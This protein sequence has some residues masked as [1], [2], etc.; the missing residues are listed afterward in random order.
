MFLLY[1]RKEFEMLLKSLEI[2]GF[3]TFPDKTVLRFENGYVAVVG[4]NGSGKSNVSDAIRW[5]M[6]EQSIKALR[7]KKMEEVIF[8]GTSTRKP[9][10]YAEVT[11]N[12][13]NTSRTLKYDDDSIKVTRRYYRSGESEYLINNAMVRLKDINELFMDTGL[14]R[15]GYSVIAQGSIE[16]IISAKGEDRRAIFEEASGI[17]KYRYR[18]IEA[19]R[20]LEKTNENLVRLEDILRELQ[21]RVEPLRIQSEKAQKFLE[22]DKEKKDLEIGLWLNTL[23]HSAEILR[24]NENNLSVSQ[25][26]YNE[27]SSDLEKAT[28]DIENNISAMNKK[29]MDIEG[30]HK[31][32]ADID[33]FVLNTKGQVSVL[34]NDIVHLKAN[35]D[36]IQKEIDESAKSQKTIDD[37]ISDNSRLANDKKDKTDEENRQYVKLSLELE[38]LRKDYDAFS[39][40]IDNKSSAIE[41]YIDD[42]SEKKIYLS[43]LK[44][45]LE[46]LNNKNGE[47]S[48]NLSTESNQCNILKNEIKNKEND[49]TVGLEKV[50]EYNNVINGYEIKIKSRQDK[51][52]YLK[53]NYEK[54]NLNYKEQERR[55]QILEELEKNYE[56]FSQSVKI[57]M[58]ESDSGMLSGI[59][60]TVTNIFETDAK[61]SIAVETA[62]GAGIQNIVVESDQSARE[63]IEFLKKRNAG[64][65]TFLPLNTIQG[66]KADLRQIQNDEGYIGIASD[67]VRCDVKFDSIKAFLLGRTLVADTLP[68]ALKLARKIQFKN[69]IVSLDGQTVNA[70]GS[71][72]GGSLVKNAGLLGRKTEIE[73]L[74]LKAQEF[75]NEAIE[76][77]KNLDEVKIHLN[78]FLALNE[79][80]KAQKQEMENSLFRLKSEKDLLSQRLEATN[81]HIENLNKD[82]ENNKNE[83]GDTEKEIAGVNIAAEKIS[84]QIE[85]LRNESTDLNES[86]G[87]QLEKCNE[88]SE[89]LQNIKLTIT[90]LQKDRENLEDI[91][92][93]LLAQKQSGENNTEQLRKQYD[94]NIKH[95]DEIKEKIDNMNK[96][97]EMSAA[98]SKTKKVEMG[99]A[100]SERDRLE[101]EST[102]LRQREREL[103]ENKENIS[104]ELARLQEKNENLKKEYDEIIEDLWNEYELT[105]H[106]AEEMAIVIEDVTASQKRLNTLKNKI[107]ALG[108]VNVGA[109]VEYKEVS[110]RYEFMNAQINDIEKAKTDLQSLIKQLSDDMRQQFMKKFAIINNN[111]ASIFSELFGGGSA[112]LY[113][114]DESDILNS[115]IEIDVHP[116]GKIVHSIESL[117][118]GEKAL[119][120]LSIYFAIMKVNPPPFCLL[121]EVEAALDDANVGRFADYLRRMND[122][123]QFILITH[124][125][126]SMEEAD[127]LYGVTMQEYGVSKLLELSLTEAQK[128][129]E[130]SNNVRSNKE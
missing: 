117:S 62:L 26:Q 43:S 61:Y 83:I 114:S 125:R 91:I 115:G 22:Y 9:M 33:E 56:G 112:S 46:S 10:G 88:I 108:N 95:I 79:T 55:A 5:V 72:T 60:G 66:K 6:G 41:K 116:P 2:Q 121:D 4:P 111:F 97:M 39:S 53:N 128:T 99:E 80:A 85:G 82:I 36:R 124:R 71:L 105:K 107:K 113:F 70:G 24:D 129:L 122:N 42:L 58:K 74:R 31:E 78:E 104:H 27:I 51:S 77:K 45:T 19:E 3:K 102:G 18:K 15:D 63:A 59:L 101:E 127:I 96:S 110:E 68:N 86:K 30:L 37:E 8:E 109:V 89:K 75:N 52:D 87:K 100:S 40:E 47:L 32:I 93:R 14:G 49:I 69:R 98:E 106:Q 90:E 25:N 23:N 20:Q 94:E 73:R 44:T 7:C 16:N 118:G 28:A 12:I 38:E 81:N 76:L 130:S 13:D 34:E 57:V 103:T 48:E 29:I 84:I 17:S 21:E 65:A 50:S 120:A 1:Y 11:L 123:T 54:A 119:I 92:R 67:L 35:A 64:R 126:G